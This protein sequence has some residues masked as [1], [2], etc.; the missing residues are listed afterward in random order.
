MQFCFLVRVGGK[1]FTAPYNQKTEQIR[2]PTST[3]GS[4]SSS[5]F[6]AFWSLIIQRDSEV[7]K[8]VG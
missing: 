3:F 7:V 6:I 4:C 1:V 2:L 8:K 5:L